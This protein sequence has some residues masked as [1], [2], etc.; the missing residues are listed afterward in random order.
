MA[1]HTFFGI[2]ALPIVD[3]VYLGQWQAVSKNV[4][5]AWLVNST[6]HICGVL[7]GRL[8]STVSRNR[9]RTPPSSGDAS[10]ARKRRRRAMPVVVSP[11]LSCVGSPNFGA[12]FLPANARCRSDSRRKQ[13]LPSKWGPTPEA[14]SNMTTCSGLLARSYAASQKFPRHVPELIRAGALPRGP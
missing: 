6:P 8:F 11:Y 4:Q 9:R 5:N 14:P 7:A 10:G 3:S 13:P 12:H 2:F 1:S